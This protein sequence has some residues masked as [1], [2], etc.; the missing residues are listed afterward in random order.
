MYA[1]SSLDATSGHADL[2]HI[3]ILQTEMISEV[4]VRDDLDDSGI[5][6]IRCRSRW[7][8]QES[9]SDDRNQLVH[10]AE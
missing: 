4:G 6:S 2:E 8:P 1:S 10:T 7:R 5:L 9:L 3:A